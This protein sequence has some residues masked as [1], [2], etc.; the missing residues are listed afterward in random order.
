MDH[1]STLDKPAVSW[2]RGEVGIHKSDIDS[3]LNRIGQLTDEFID[4]YLRVNAEAC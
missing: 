3:I 1:A 4:E 2:E